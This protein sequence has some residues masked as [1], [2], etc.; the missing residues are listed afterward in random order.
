MVTEPVKSSESVPPH[1]AAASLPSAHPQA[2]AAH[3]ASRRRWIIGILVLVSAAILYFG[4]PLVHEALTTVSTDDAYVNSH[5]TSVAARVLGQVS[6]VYVDDNNRV[7]AG[8][9]LV[10]LDDQPYRVIVEIKEAALESAKADLM[11]AK[12][13]VRGYAGQIRSARWKLQRTIEDIH[14]QVAALRAKVAAAHQPEGGF[15]TGRGRFPS[16]RKAAEKLGH[17]P[18][19]LRNAARSV[20]GGSSPIATSAG[21]GLPNAS[22]TRIA[23]DT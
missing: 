8:D 19:R 21:R 18:G 7:R 15:G 11:A 1:V 9:L 10:Q 22:R 16:G 5:V 17:Q 3:P 20:S 14:N 4:I 6:K 23:I 13:K 12:T 2:P